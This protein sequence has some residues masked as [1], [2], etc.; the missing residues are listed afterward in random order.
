MLEIQPA[1]E[2]HLR[3]GDAVPVAVWSHLGA[4]PP[5]RKSSAA[6]RTK[7]VPDWAGVSCKMVPKG[8]QCG[9]LA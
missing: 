6:S 9:R 3:Q 2:M 1:V 8:R 4:G 7:L 5:E